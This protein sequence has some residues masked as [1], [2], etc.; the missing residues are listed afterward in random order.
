LNVAGVGRQ[1]N[2]PGVREFAPNAVDG[3]GA[4]QTRHLEIHQGYVP[5]EQL[6]IH[7]AQQM[8]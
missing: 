4:I 5:L 7:R 6:Q 8:V 2:Y 1:D 3:L